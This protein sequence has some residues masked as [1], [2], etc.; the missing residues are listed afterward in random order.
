MAEDEERFDGMLM[1]MAQ[2]HE[3]GI[4]QLINT[5]FGF[6]RRKTDFFVGAQQGQAEKVVIDCFKTHQRLATEAKKKKEEEAAAA[7]KAREERQAK[8][9]AAKLAAEAKIK[10]EPK[11]QE[12]TDEEAERLQAELDQKKQ[13]A[14][15][16]PAEEDKKNSEKSNKDGSDD[17]EEESE[18]DKAKLKPNSGNGADLPNYRWTQTLGELEVHIPMP[19]PVK[20]RD[21][22]V[23]I[24]KRHLRAGLKGH[25]PLLDGETYNELKVEECSW[26]IQDKKVVILY[27]EK[28][29]K[30]E[31]WDKLVSSDPSINTKKVNP[32]NSKLSDLEGETRSMVEKMMYDQRQKAMGLPTSE[33][34][35]KQEILQKFMKQHPEMDFSNA[36][37]N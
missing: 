8:E 11:I 18:E 28:I 37:F 9:K 25:D 33:D 34:Q 36:K 22:V 5:F 6:L 12:L 14:E 4:Q 31:W 19:M 1:A 3:Q 20:S 2:Q 23:A 27:L 10:E 21:L 32:E 35:K 13:Q 16:A 26:V 29:N 30:M 24:D 17:D 15:S 7:M